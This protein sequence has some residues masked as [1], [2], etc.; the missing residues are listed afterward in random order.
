MDIVPFIENP[1][2]FCQNLKSTFT[3]QHGLESNKLFS[4]MFLKL[5][6]TSEYIW[7]KI[8][9]AKFYFHKNLTVPY[10]MF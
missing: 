6:F 9:S 2:Y 4:K 7:G 3:Y 5:K 10:P 1:L 8:S